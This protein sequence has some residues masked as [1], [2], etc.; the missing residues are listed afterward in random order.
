MIYDIIDLFLV[1]A[2]LSSV[3]ICAFLLGSCD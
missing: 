3:I 1:I 2:T